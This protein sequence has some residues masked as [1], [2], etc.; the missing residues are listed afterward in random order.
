MIDV[1]NARG[2]I[3]LNRRWDV[4]KHLLKYHYLG[5]EDDQWCWLI[6][7]NSTRTISKLKN[8]HYE[9]TRAELRCS[10]S[11]GPTAHEKAYSDLLLAAQDKRII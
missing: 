9:T 10:H 11:E 5:R 3:T 6:N 4:M 7:S 2:V 8:W 1:H